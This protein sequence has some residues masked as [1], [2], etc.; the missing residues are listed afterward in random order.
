MDFSRLKS[1]NTQFII[2]IQHVLLLEIFPYQVKHRF[3]HVFGNVKI[4]MIVTQLFILMIIR[5]VQCLVKLVQQVVLNR[6]EALAQMSYVIE[7]IIVNLIFDLKY[8]YIFFLLV[9]VTTCSSTA[10]TVIEVTTHAMP[11]MYTRFVSIIEGLF[12]TNIYQNR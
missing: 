5:L 11:R 2:R 12:G 6:L 7:K 9:P 4:K 10:A 1:I 8:Q 3:K